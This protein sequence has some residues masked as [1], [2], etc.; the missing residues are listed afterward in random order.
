MGLGYGE[1]PAALPRRTITG[2]LRVAAVGE[3]EGG[4]TRSEAGG[5]RQLQMFACRSCI[6]SGLRGKSR[7]CRCGRL[8]A[9]MKTQRTKRE[10]E[11]GVRANKTTRNRT[12]QSSMVTPPRTPF[13]L[14]CITLYPGTKCS[15]R[16]LLR[17]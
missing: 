14:N 11:G 3:E 17:N 10:R 9:R 12:N 13:F 5:A 2:A 4:C 1:T 6:S 15:C 16:W 7:I 8:R